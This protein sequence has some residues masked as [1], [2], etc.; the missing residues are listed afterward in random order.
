MGSL[1]SHSGVSG[2]PQ[3]SSSLG[4]GSSGGLVS[5]EVGGVSTQA[6]ATSRTAPPQLWAEG[7]PPPTLGR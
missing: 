6:L 5:V 2:D 7:P 4:Q 1:F 3:M